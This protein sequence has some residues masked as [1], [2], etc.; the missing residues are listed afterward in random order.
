MIKLLLFAPCEKFINGNDNVASLIAIL[1]HIALVKPAT[2][3]F[4]EDASIPF[5]WTAVILWN[6]IEEV[7]EPVRFNIKVEVVAPNGQVRMVGGHN[8]DVL[9]PYQNFRNNIDFPVFPIGLPGVYHITLS[10]KRDDA[11]D[12]ITA[13]EYPV[14]VI[15]STKDA[16]DQNTTENP[17]EN[18]VEQS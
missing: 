7:V 12:W 15:H 16:A 13:G 2:E 18:P 17:I 3:E 5:R 14:N 4:P 10:Y 11:E 1:E 8:F 9:G 6:R